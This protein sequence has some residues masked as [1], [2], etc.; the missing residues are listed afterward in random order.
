[1]L[2]RARNPVWLARALGAR[3]FA[4]P[5]TRASAPTARG[6]GRAQR[7]WLSKPRASG[8]GH[9]IAEWRPGDPLP[10][11]RVLQ[12]R[13]D[14]VPG[15]VAFAADGR[16]AAPFAISRQLV[17]DRAFGASGFK[18]C[19]SILAAA[20]DALGDALDDALAACATALAVAVTEECGLVGVNGVDFVA[21]GGVPFPVEVNPRHSASMELAERAY[22]FSV[23][24][25]HARGCRGELVRFDLGAARRAA[26]GAVGKAVLYARR[27]VTLGDTRRWLEDDSVRDVPHPGETIAR[28]RPVCTVFARGRDGAECYAALVRRAEMLYEEIDGRRR[29]IA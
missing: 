15:S 18:Y 19:G 6:R 10:R 3:G 7:G 4:V 13:I 23:F 5:V 20:G 29:R 16:G 22:G 26:A 14:G 9:G 1:V 8:G 11:A 17:G 24:D 25:A 21:R 12:E 27:T 28:G 2:A